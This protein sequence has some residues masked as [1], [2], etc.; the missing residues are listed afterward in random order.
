MW[1]F[2]VAFA[3]LA[4][5]NESKSVVIKKSAISSA[6]SEAILLVSILSNR[7]VALPTFGLVGC[8]QAQ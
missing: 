7:E 2:S 5:A 1:K 6:A 3:S 4:I 8:Q